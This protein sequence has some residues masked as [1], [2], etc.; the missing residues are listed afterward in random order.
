MVES[1]ASS[2]RRRRLRCTLSVR[3]SA[4]VRRGAAAALAAAAACAAAAVQHNAHTLRTPKHE[5]HYRNGRRCGLHILLSD[6]VY[7]RA[8]CCSSK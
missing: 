8:H 1:A 4:G 7:R 2:S 3:R 6:T 5:S